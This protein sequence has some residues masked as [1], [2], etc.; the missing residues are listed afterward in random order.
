MLRVGTDAGDEDGLKARCERAGV[1]AGLSKRELEV[2]GLLYRGYSAKRI[3]EVLYVSDNTVRSHTSNIYKQMAVHS[4][5]E[6]MMLVDRY[7]D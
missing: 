3:A 6:L 4:K 7:R 2:M 5:Q 1:A